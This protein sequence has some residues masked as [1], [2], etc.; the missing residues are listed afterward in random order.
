M[1]KIIYRITVLLLTLFIIGCGTKVNKPSNDEV[2]KAYQNASE[3]SNWFL[4]MSLPT[5]PNISGQYNGEKDYYKVLKYKNLKELKTYISSL[6]SEQLVDEFIN[7][8]IYVEIDGG[9]YSRNGA[10]GADITK[11]NEIN[12]EYKSESDKKI[13]LTVEVELLDSNDLNK[14]IGTEK[15]DFTYELIGS[16]WVFTTFPT[17]R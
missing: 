2:L 15:H 8:G 1:K 6:F 3:A 17:I 12:Y 13:I 5:D 4:V 10:R 7:M 11:G 9:L 14:V 16:N